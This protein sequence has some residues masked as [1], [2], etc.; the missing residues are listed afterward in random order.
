MIY[1]LHG[2]DDFSKRDFLAGLRRDLCTPELLE[3][4]TTILAGAGMILLVI[5]IHLNRL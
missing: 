4:N 3:A 1:L 2:E 5:L